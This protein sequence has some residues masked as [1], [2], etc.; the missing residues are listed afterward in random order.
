MIWENKVFIPV[1]RDPQFF[2]FVDRAIESPHPPP[3]LYW[4]SL[5]KCARQ[6]EMDLKSF[7][8]KDRAQYWRR[9]PTA[10]MWLYL[11]LWK[12]R[13]IRDNG[14][15]FSLCMLTTPKSRVL[16]NCQKVNFIEFKSCSSYSACF[17]NQPTS[18]WQGLSS[19]SSAVIFQNNN[20]KKTSASNRSV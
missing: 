18:P 2:P 19:T 15:H 20:N 9:K 7:S 5:R 1:I 6:N 14:Q 17:I 13:F 8:E 12:N 11:L 16:W 4:T 10:K 3:P